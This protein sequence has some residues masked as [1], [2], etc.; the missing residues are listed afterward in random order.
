V[1]HDRGVHFRPERNGSAVVGGHFAD[2][3]P[4]MDP[5]NYKK[6][7]DLD[8]AAETIAAA[9]ECANYFGPDSRVKRGWAGLYGVTPDHHPILEETLPGFVTAAG[10]SGHGFMQ[11]PAT[12]KIVAEL[13]D[14]GEPSLVDISSLT[15][16]R[17]ERGV[18]L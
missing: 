4:R 2:T 10:F 15:A 18:L 5:D 13:I 7:M 11:A 3:D 1:D 12:G 9:A 16:D 6:N 8:W 14:E 17:F